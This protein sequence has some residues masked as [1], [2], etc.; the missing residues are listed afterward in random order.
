LQAFYAQ[1]HHQP[2]SL[3]SLLF[4]MTQNGQLAR[5]LDPVYQSL[6]ASS[7]NRAS[8]SPTKP[9]WFEDGDGNGYIRQDTIEGRKEYVIME[10]QG[11]GCLTR[12]W[13]PFFYYSLDNHKEPFICIYILMERRILF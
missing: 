4:E 13:T 7:Y 12:M 3:R 6:Q 1:A 8:V 9:G 11:P 10:H 2:V 5:F